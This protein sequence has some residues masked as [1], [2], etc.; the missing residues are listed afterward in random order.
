MPKA[1]TPQLS[2][3]LTIHQSGVPPVAA[4]RGGAPF[5]PW[6]GQTSLPPQSY[7]RMPR[8]ASSYHLLQLAAHPDAQISREN[9][10]PTSDP[11]PTHQH[12]R[13]THRSYPLTPDGLIL[14]ARPVPD[15]LHRHLE[16]HRKRDHDLPWGFVLLHL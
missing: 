2:V 11:R 3:P 10:H 16:G 6:K 5:P 4:H 14:C 13:H 7:H 15:G 9:S 8:G 12:Q 1:P